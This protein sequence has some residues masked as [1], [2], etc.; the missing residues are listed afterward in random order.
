M[1]QIRAAGR[2]PGRFSAG[3][4]L[5]KM[6]PPSMAG[7]GYQTAL[8]ALARA[9]VER[10]KSWLDSERDQYVL[11][12]PVLFGTGVAA[13]FALPGNLAWSGWLCIS[14]AI[15]LASLLFRR[16]GAVGRRL[17]LVAGL[18]LALGCAAA[19][20]RSAIVA[21]P[22]LA[23]PAVVR[24]TADVIAVEPQPARDATRLLLRLD[25]RV[26]LPAIVRVNVPTRLTDHVTLAAGNRIAVRARLMPP[27]SPILPGAYDFARNAWFRQIGAVGSVLAIEAH[28]ARP[29]GWLSQARAGLFAHI[30]AA[31]PPGTAGVAIAF[32]TGSEGAIQEDDSEAMRRAGLAH[33]LSISG[34]H[35]S[36]AV[37]GAMWL[38]LRLMALWPGLALRRPLVIYAAL[39]GALV[40]IGYTLLT[41][42]QVPTIR[43]LLAALAVLLA[44]VLG[45]E[46]MSMRLVAVGA[47]VILVIWPESLVGASFQ[48]SFAAIIAIVALHGHSR[49]AGWFAHRDESRWRRVGRHILSLL[50][51]GLVVEAALMPIAFYHFHRSGVYGALANIIA[52]PLTTLV[53]MPLELFALLLDII[54]IGAPA[55]WLVDRAIASLIWLAHLVADAPGSVTALPVVP[56]AAFGLCI[57]GGLWCALWTRWPRWLGLPLIAAGMTWSAM[58]PAADLL[59]TSDGRHVAARMD[60]GRYYLLRDRTG[61]FAR[62]QLAEAAGEL[63][64]LPLLSD[65]RGARCN[66]DFCLW[67]MQ[68]GGR[69]WH[70]LAARS[71]YLSDWTSL[72]RACAASDIVIADRGLPRGCVPR[73]LKIDRFR[74]RQ[75]GG[76]AID[77][78]RER[79]TTVGG[80]ARGM[81]WASPPTVMP[82][83]PPRAV[84]APAVSGTGVATP[85][86]SPGLPRDAPHTPAPDRLR[87]PDQAAPAARR[88]GNI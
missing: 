67:T 59:I 17:L 73:W 25:P 48:L 22:V 85:P 57:F 53:I 68:R 21:A 11:W 80:D 34:L 78:A 2:R 23:R 20:A 40:G 29:A 4:V 36:A 42:A 79:V 69:D 27:A 88:D 65:A 45:R 16:P 35:V 19:W 28:A 82:P 64:E 58:T 52:I 26:G 3:L 63:D 74:L 55:W 32:A 5:A 9:I 49:V 31:L 30:R 61:D 66:A 10:A 81:P 8:V 72:V 38:A 87:S 60:D 44:I 13:W 43:S 47:L 84:T 12:L 37:G 18:A 86:A 46:P 50:L 14:A 83:R 39:F 71:N 7:T 1:I 54:G 24:F 56:D 6:G 33:L 76:I 77:L 70:V 41:G 75:S 15:A 62:E 51:T